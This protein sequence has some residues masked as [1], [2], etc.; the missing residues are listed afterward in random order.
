M[1][2]NNSNQF[3]YDVALSFAGE[4]RTVVEKFADLLIEKNIKVFYDEY[5]AVDLWGRNL[6][7]H[8]S[9]IY[10]KKA[11][12]CVIFISQYYPLKKWTNLERTFAQERAFHDSNEYILPI[13]LDDTEVP[14]IADTIGYR[15][16]R[17]H[18]LDSIANSLSEKIAK[19]KG[20]TNILKQSNAASQ[21]LDRSSLPAFNSIPMPKPKKTFTQLQ[22]D[23]F[24]KEAFEI[25]KKYFQQA[26]KQLENIDADVETDFTEVTNVEFTSKIYLQGSIKSQCSIWMGDM[27]MLGSP[28]AIYYSEGRQR[29]GHNSYNDYLPVEDNGESLCLQIGSFGIG[30]IHVDKS[31]ATQQEAAEYLWRRHSAHLEHR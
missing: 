11:R 3:E 7:D 27:P 18:P 23:R 24:L 19:A 21:P 25:I 14:G 15:D 13:K 8:L 12:Y 20:Q 6:V 22:K 1:S 30:V 4:D 16:L 9:E 29:S 28:N 2:M 17:Q 5:S 31:L 26:L 10:S